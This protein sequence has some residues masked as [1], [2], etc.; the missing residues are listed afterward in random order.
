MKKLKALALISLS[1]FI[2][3]C[4]EGSND[5]VERVVPVKTYAISSENISSYI[6]LTGNVTAEDDAIIYS[7]TTEK[8]EKIYV[9]PGQH[10]SAGQILVMQYNAIYRE[11]L[12]TAKAALENA[13]AQ[14]ELT[15]QN[16][17]RTERLFQQNAVSQQQY[18]QM[19]TAYTAA[20]A[21]YNQA[22]AAY[23]QTDE[24]YQNTFVKAPFS[25]IVAAIFIETNQMAPAGIPMVQ[26]VKPGGLKA[27]LQLSSKDISLIKIGQTVKIKF[28]SIP[29][30]EFE[31]FV[32][33]IDHAIDPLTKA[34]KIEVKFKD[35][36]PRIKSGLFGEFYIE[37][38]KKENTI[39][40][41]DYSII[42]QTEV[43]INKETGQQEPIRRNFVFKIEN[44]K[45]KLVEL[46]V[47]LSS[48]GRI[49]VV[50]GLNYKDTII[51]VGQNV[52][53]DGQSIKII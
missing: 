22:F 29:E 35:S 20:E 3:G 32:A 19:K 14:F 37:I 9:V 25:G 41:P 40:I 51:I 49:Q 46:G 11:G 39:V 52:V 8:V 12:A 48:E 6:R 24:Q 26:V 38:N 28:P 33:Q 34:L 50:S 7:K 53:K 44:N 36:D 47:G 17:E 16:F 5:E 4:Q 31:G 45:A 2:F 15:K 42:T 10:V 30:A 13:K 27:K 1:L 21:M 43:S 23:N 18:D